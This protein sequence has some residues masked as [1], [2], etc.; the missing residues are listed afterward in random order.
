MNIEEIKITVQNV[1]NNATGVVV[2]RAN[3][4]TPRPNVDFI[5]FLLSSSVETGTESKTKAN[6]SGNITATSNRDL[7]WSLQ[8]R[9]INAFQ[10]L[11]DLRSNILTE[12][13]L[14]LLRTGG[15]AFVNTG[16]VVDLTG[17]LG[18][19]ERE[20]RAQMDLFLRIGNQRTENTGIIEKVTGT[21]IILDNAG[22]PFNI[23]F[24]ANAT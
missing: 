4:N 18:E 9:S 6:S 20:T 12:T 5:S 21:G 2:I 1:I 24:S 8:C 11:E 7:M 22:T 10:I 23:E 3:Q 15:L 14:N 16:N 17:M 19:G 13:N